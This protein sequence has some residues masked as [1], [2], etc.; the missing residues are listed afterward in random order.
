M[1]GRYVFTP[2]NSKK[3]KDRFNLSNQLEIEENYNVAPG[4][5]VSVV[6]R[7]SPNKAV[8]MR[9]GLVPFWAKDPK[10]GYKMINARVETV[11]YKPSFRKAVRSQRCLVPA[12]GF[13][14]WQRVDGKQPYYITRKD[15]K[16]M[17]FAGI[18]DIWKDAKGKELFSYS[19]ITTKA[20]S[21]VSLI[22]NRMPVILDRKKEDEWLEENITDPNEVK[23]FLE[24]VS[25][26]ELQTYPVSKA[27]NKATINTKKL[28]E[29]LIN[30]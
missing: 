22:H 10:I 21:L 15:E 13:Y 27:V 28:I 14:E 25:E 6:I 17:A 7:K 18:Y 16:M 9:W 8:K 19:I 3:F 1:C 2:G 23:N 30:E 12:N 20:N 24:P 5:M 26:Q 11:L 4:Q 29:P